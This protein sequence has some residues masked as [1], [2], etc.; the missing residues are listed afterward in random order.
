MYYNLIE[1]QFKPMVI[2]LSMFF[3]PFFLVGIVA[4]FLE[5]NIGVLLV[6]LMFILAYIGFIMLVRKECNNKNYYLII[7]DNKIEI[8]HPDE[9]KTKKVVEICY[10]DIIQL[11][12]Y[13]LCSIISWVQMFLGGSC[14]KSVYI[15]YNKYK[16]FEKDVCDL[17]GYMDLQDIKKIAMDKNIKLVI[18]TLIN[19]PYYTAPPII[20]N[21]FSITSY[22]NT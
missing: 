22:T 21:L 14:P 6:L 10:E 13:R 5:F 12:Y 18:K 7:H 8:N 1:K 2:F 17:V 9:H 4:L 3:Y 19:T 11:E 20:V 15:T 16:G